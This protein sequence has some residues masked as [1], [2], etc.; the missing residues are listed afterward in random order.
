[1]VYAFGLNLDTSSLDDVKR[2][3]SHLEA[4]HS[5]WPRLQAFADGVWKSSQVGR[6]LEFADIVRVVMKIGQGY[7]HW[8]GSDCTRAKEE[9][10]AKPSH[11][12]G[13]VSMSEV[14]PSHAFGRRSLFT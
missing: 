7:A 9:L 2:A 5:G 4:S 11:K 3:K 12:Q 1:M 14:A 10:A 6:D 8:Q 13:L